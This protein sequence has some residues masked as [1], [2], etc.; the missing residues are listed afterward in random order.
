M[1]LRYRVIGFTVSG[2]SKRMAEIKQTKEKIT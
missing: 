1:P 2:M